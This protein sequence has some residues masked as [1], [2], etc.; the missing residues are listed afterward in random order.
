M[1]EADGPMVVAAAKL[2]PSVAAKLE[3]LARDG[4][5]SKSMVIR[6]LVERALLTDLGVHQPARTEADPS[7]RL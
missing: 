7:T 6:L 3:R 4:R 2:P 1:Y 5:R